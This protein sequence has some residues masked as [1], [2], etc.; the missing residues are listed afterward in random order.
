MKIFEKK[1]EPKQGD[2]IASYKQN[3][4]KCAYQANCLLERY[5]SDFPLQMLVYK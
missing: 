1:M 5:G 4:K 2:L 3:N